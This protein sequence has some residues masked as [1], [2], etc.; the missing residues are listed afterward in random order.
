MTGIDRRTLL[1]WQ[2]RDRDFDAAIS[3]AEGRFETDLHRTV[4]AGALTNPMLALRLLSL[5]FPMRYGR[6]VICVQCRGWAVR[7]GD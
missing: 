7:I 3:S 4:V 5:R 2:R 1:R 6:R